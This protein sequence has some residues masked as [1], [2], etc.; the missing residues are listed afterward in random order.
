M[1]FYPIRRLCAQVVYEKPGISH[2]LSREVHQSFH[3]VVPESALPVNLSK[4]QGQS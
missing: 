4:G 1:V 2:T 3:S